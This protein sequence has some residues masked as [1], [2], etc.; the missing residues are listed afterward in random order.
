M[1]NLIVKTCFNQ[2]LIFRL[3]SILILLVLTIH[4]SQSFANQAGEAKYIRGITTV[5]N[6]AG[7]I[8]VLGKGGAF[9]QGDEIYTGKNS[10]AIIQFTDNTKMTL[11]PNTTFKVNQYVYKPQ[12]PEKNSGFFSLIRGGLRAITGLLN[13]RKLN[14]MRLKTVNAT[15]GIRG[16]E[17]DARLCEEDC[18]ADNKV[19]TASKSKKPIG[20]KAVGRVAFLRGALSADNNQLDKSRSLTTGGPIYE[21]DLL[22]TGF[23]GFAVI[24]F[25][26]KS[27][28][29]LRRNSELLIEQF[30]FKPSEPKANVSIFQML[31]GGFRMLTGQVAKLNRQRTRIH[32]LTATIGVRGTGFD[33]LCQGDCGATAEN[34][35]AAPLSPLSRLFGS[36]IRPAYAQQPQN[37]MYVYVWDGAV[38]LFQ[39]TLETEL[40]AGFSSFLRDSVNPPKVVKGEPLSMEEFDAPRP[41][42]VEI[43]HEQLFGTQDSTSESPPNGLYVSVYEGHVVV[44]DKTGAVTDIGTGEALVVS[45]SGVAKRLPNLPAFQVNDPVPSPEN[46]NQQQQNQ[47]DMSDL[48]NINK[49]AIGD[50]QK[51]LE[52]SIR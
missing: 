29:T 28:V 26:D 39:Q 42:E 36:L 34:E 1:Q 48:L 20:Q 44:K 46:F 15:I 49:D 25:S 38:T 43:N 45:T 4:P 2:I 47:Q 12:E 37:G 40:S 16:T 50:N 23:S 24:A 22:K 13:K 32:T 7:K 3:A 19:K 30:K 9:F 27:R 18:A 21:S 41:D 10:F 35:T 11:R 31:R 51:S 17:F 8:N 14:A 6:E 52:C 5:K 33:L